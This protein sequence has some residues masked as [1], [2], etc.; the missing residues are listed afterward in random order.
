MCSN[1]KKWALG[2]IASLFLAGCGGGGGSSPTNTNTIPAVETQ[3]SP[4]PTPPGTDPTT[5]PT[6]PEV[7]NQEIIAFHS[8]QVVDFDYAQRAANQ[9]VEASQ[10]QSEAFANISGHFKFPTSGQDLQGNLYVSVNVSDPD[11]I[12]NVFVGFEGA[13]GA[14]AVCTSSCGNSVNR[15]ITGINPLQL[16]LNSNNSSNQILQLWSDDSQGNRTH[17]SQVSINWQPVKVSGISATRAV[18]SINLSWSL[19]TNYLRYNVYLSTDSALSVQNYQSVAIARQHLSLTNNSVNIT[20]L[21][22][23]TMLYALV[24]GIDGGGESAFGTKLPIDPL[25][26]PTNLAPVANND[27]FEFIEDDSLTGNLLANDTDPDNEA[28]FIDTTPVVN[29]ENGTL[30]INADGTFNYQPPINFVGLEQF[31]YRITDAA[32][33]SAQAVAT[34]LITPQ[35]DDPVALDNTY[36]IQISGETLDV[37]A[38]GLLANDYDIDVDTLV[39]DTTPVAPPSNGAVV[40]Q[41]NGSFVYTPNSGFIGVD[42]FTYQVSDASGARAQ[43]TTTITVGQSNNPPTAQNDSYTINEN[44]V[45]STAADGLAS[46]LAND[47]DGDGDNLTVVSIGAPQHGTRTLGQN[48]HFS[49]IPAANFYGVDNMVYQLSDGTTTTTAS[50]TII[51]LPQNAPPQA[52]PDSGYQVAEDS[53]LTVSAADG[54]LRNDSDSDGDE[55]RVSNVL[56]ANPRQGSVT[57]NNDGSFIYIPQNNFTGND[58][59]TYTVLDSFGQ[60]D[61]AVVSISVTPVNDAPVAVNDSAI[62]DINTPVTINVLENDSDIDGDPLSITAAT[63][64]TGSVIIS[65]NALIYTPATNFNGQDNIDYTISDGAGQNA[66]ASVTVTINENL[67]APVA[68]D[69]SYSGVEDTKLNTEIS[70]LASL[71]ANDSDADGDVLSVNITPVSAPIKGSILLQ[72]NGHFSYTPNGNEVGSDSFVYQLQDGNGGTATATAIIAITPVNDAPTAVDDNY[73]ITENATLV[74][75]VLDND[76]DIDGDSITITG[77]SANTGNVTILSDTNLQYTAASGFSGTD[78]ITYNISDGNGGS[79]SANV[80]V[81]ISGVNDAPVVVDDIA[82][83][84]EDT[85][86]TIDVLANDS[87][88]EGDNLTVTVN[89][90][91]NGTH[92]VNTDN[93]I[94]FIPTE[95]FNGEAIITYN[96]ADP[97]GASDNG[98]VTITVVP[99]NDNP[100]ANADIFSLDE[101][102]S[103]QINPISNDTD[104]EDDTLSISSATSTNATI[105]TNSNNSLTYTPNL[106]FFGTDIVSYQLLDNQGGIATG[107]ITVTVNPVSDLPVASADSYQLDEDIVLAVDAANGILSNDSDPDGDNPTI[108][109]NLIEV[110]KHGTLEISFDGSFVYTPQSNFVGSDS[111]IYQIIDNTGNTAQATVTLTINPVNDAPVAVNDSATTSVNTQVSILVLAND[112]DIDGDTLFISAANAD[113]GTVNITGTSLTYQP[114]SDFAGTD[115]INYTIGDGAGGTASAQVV[116]TINSNQ[117]PIAV[118]DSYSISEDTILTVPDGDNALSLLAN[119]SDPEGSSL[120]VGSTAIAEPAHGSL[121]L[122]SDGSFVYT[123]QSDFA[124]TDSFI[125]QLTDSEGGTA[126]GTA[127]ITVLGINDTPVGV[128]DSYTV[129][130]NSITIMAVLDN[131]TDVDGDTLSVTAATANVGTVVVLA[132]STLQY[133]APSG[134]NTSDSIEYNISDGQGGTTFANVAITIVNLNDAPVAV[135]DSASTDEDSSITFNVLDNDT[136]AD[137]DTLTIVSVTS[138]NG[139][140]EVHQDNSI[141]FTPAENFNGET[142]LSYTISD[143]NDGTATGLVS[144]TVAAVNDNPIA[145]TDE[146][147]L[148]EDGSVAL[149]PTANDTDVD[150]DTL[151]LTSANSDN[152]E[153]TINGN[154][155]TY[156]PNADFNGTD[157]IQYSIDDGNNGS[158]QGI[159]VVTITAINDNPV[160]VVDEVQV[161]EGSSAN[162]IDVLVNDTDVD[163]D[164]LTLDSVTASNGSAEVLDNTVSYT[165]DAAFSGATTLTYTLSDGQGGI[166]K[167]LVNVTVSAVNDN[168]VANSD[169]F[170]VEE[171]STTDFDPTVNDTDSDGDTLTIVSATSDNAD[172]TINSANS[173]TYTLKAN[174]NGLD[175][176]RYTIEDGNGG[177]SN[178]VIFV[179]V[180]PVADLPIAVE[181]IV[182]MDEDAIAIIDVLANDSDADGDSL[183]IIAANSDQ[184]AVTVNPAEGDNSETLTFIPTPNINGAAVINY[185]ISDG[186]SDSSSGASS[187]VAVTINSVAD[188]PTINNVSGEVSE[189]ATNGV[190]VLTIGASDVDDNDSVLLSITAGDNLSVFAINSNSNNGEITV[191]DASQLDFE[192]TSSYALTITATDTTGLTSAATANITVLNGPENETPHFDTSFGNSPIAGATVSNAFAFDYQDTPVDAVMDNQGRVIMIGTTTDSGDSVNRITINRYLA[193][194]RLDHSF[195]VLGIVFVDLDVTEAAKAITVDS[196]NNIYVAGQVQIGSTNEVVIAK[197]LATKL[198]NSHLDATFGTGGVAT[199]NMGQSN[200][201]VGDILAHSDGSVFVAAGVNSEFAL[202]KYN[203]VGQLVASTTINMTGDFDQPEALAEQT[204]G[205]ILVAGHSADA[206][207]NFTYDFAVARLVNSTTG[208]EFSLDTSFATTGMTTFDLGQS[209]SDMIYA[210]ELTSTGDIVLAGTLLHTSNFCDVAVAVLDPN[211]ILLN[212]FGDGGILVLDADGDGGA[213]TG[214]AFAT[215]IDIDSNGNLFLGTQFGMTT[216]LYDFGVVKISSTGQLD[217]SF[218]SNGVAQHDI[219]NGQNTM[220]ALMLDSTDRPVI[221]TSAPGVRNQDFAISR[222]TGAGVFDTSFLNHGYNQVNQSPSD[223]TMHGALQ[224]DA[225]PHTGK[226]VMV[227]TTSSGSGLSDLIVARYNIDGSVD[228]TFGINGYFHLSTNDTDIPYVGKSITELNDG[229]VVITGQVSSTRGFLLA[230]DT[231]GKLDTSFGGGDG[232]LFI[233]PDGAE[234]ISPNSVTTDN[235]NMIVVAGYQTTPAGPHDVYLARFDALG[236]PDLSFNETGRVILDLAGGLSEGFNRVDIMPDNSLIAVGYH[237]NRALVAKFRDTGVLNPNFN[238]TGFHALDVDPQ[239]S[240]N[241]DELFDVDVDDGGHIFASGASNSATTDLITVV[242][243]NADGSMDSN[244]DSDGMVTYSFGSGHAKQSMSLD[245]NGKLVLT[246]HSHGA[247]GDDIFVARLGRNGAL[248]PIFAGGSHVLINHNDTDSSEIVGVLDNGKILI[249]GHNNFTTYP[250]RGWF[251]LMLELIEETLATREDTLDTVEDKVKFEFRQPEVVPN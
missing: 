179:T 113:N 97:S 133:T 53:S 188:A 231:N 244:F 233:L 208:P 63:A 40:L 70:G 27:A 211:G 56:A 67:N 127:T 94:T 114:N 105:T 65:N 243:I 206:A 108:T 33:A 203:S 51:V 246:G 119:D 224:M 2:L 164:T 86:V 126:T 38:P 103:G 118:D 69:D 155:I 227:G 153:I 25:S 239:V 185:T 131:D 23:E 222:F 234:T 138:E 99:V 232:S 120:S 160:G 125:Y 198:N 68:V 3:T 158:A 143:G 73:T 31:T 60:K 226:F 176:A 142:T 196:N 132:D 248:D 139:T 177:S 100:V 163:G 112:T 152:S 184:G 7:P 157:T 43:G 212:S 41:S 98:L 89:N 151:T 225:S 166:G 102:T 251:I 237:N 66:T 181:D 171:D 174:F 44:T 230:L 182:T 111:F 82:T 209:R 228:A 223:D 117:S 220:V 92:V 34:I 144:I 154:T 50:I 110:V 186:N 8:S 149:D 96:A 30:V 197:L 81:I 39:V 161:A 26:G 129:N 250:S 238:V 122:N 207:Q 240:D 101:D 48:G 168:P 169:D 24:V 124:G 85:S 193:D 116:V 87:D 90:V 80:T 17:I 36:N 189:N 5:D 210:I 245:N 145:L 45:L 175:V 218:G 15:T 219:N 173:I 109:T 146:V 1:S 180:N 37:A 195:G 46:L 140:H 242:S 187:T 216:N 128:D 130:E 16:G 58:R 107:T 165:P 6:T 21:D 134:T 84:N 79:A 167:G 75:S 194:G 178:G 42:E 150:G 78:F 247:T 215:S 91:S 13:Q 123:P 72:P 76:T 59:F 229:R 28:V 22:D 159:I 202:L 192:T 10:A 32:G 217:S 183:S 12:S 170:I 221:A 20:G 121:S 115:T 49:Y 106:N 55:L 190:H 191:N 61:T 135:N 172:I 74:M 71:I 88:A 148:D 9:P 93:T 62:T 205:K 214:N 54:V 29:V 19:V 104:I 241:V 201:L 213:G 137:N 236:N 235:N 204:D 95:N 14:V 141:T 199:S 249:A 83:T 18:N 35:N 200:V 52:N 156:V 136:D 4:P 77:A 147:T 162:I 11:G 47:S 57:I 64:G